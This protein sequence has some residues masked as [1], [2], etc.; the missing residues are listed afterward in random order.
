MDIQWYPGHMT[1]TI[2]VMREDIALVD[3]VIELLDA[4]IPRSSKNPDIDGL[5]AGKLRV[6]LLNKADLADP[7][8][9]ERWAAYFGNRGVS[10]ILADSATGKGVGRIAEACEKLMREKRDR[11]KARGRIFVTARAMIVGIPNVGKSTLINRLAGRA[12]AKTADRPGV[13]R[14]KQWIKAG[15]NLELLDTPGILWPKFDDPDVGMRLAFIGAIKDDVLDV[16]N[17]A[18]K[19]TEALLAVDPACFGKR[20]G[21]TDTGGGPERLLELVARARGFIMKGAQP[22]VERAAIMLIDE[23]RAGRLGRITLEEP[24]DGD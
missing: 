6:A 22:D 23:F 13:T 9:N 3:I 15:K 17:L 12:A 20:Y 11:L 7:A 16:Y 21:V 10:A 18:L 5:A 4:R 2:R 19:L 14:G 24:G 8:L 1:K